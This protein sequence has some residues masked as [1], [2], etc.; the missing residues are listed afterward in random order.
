MPGKAPLGARLLR[1]M[2]RRT[3]ITTLAAA[4]NRIKRFARRSMLM[5]PPL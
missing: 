2:D 1:A 3:R 4:A 5:T